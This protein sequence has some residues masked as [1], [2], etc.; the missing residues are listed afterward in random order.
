MEASL[1]SFKLSNTNSACV[2]MYP[3][4]VSR[5]RTDLEISLQDY[6]NLRDVGDKHLKNIREGSLA[7]AQLPTEEEEVYV[8]LVFLRFI[9][10]K[11]KRIF[12]L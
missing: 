12:I 4:H 11:R 6:V 3:S 8:F 10:I 7:L 5:R 2:I 9:Y 1:K